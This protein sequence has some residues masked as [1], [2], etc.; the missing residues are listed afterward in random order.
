MEIRNGLS[1]ETAFIAEDSSGEMTSSMAKV[2]DHHFGGNDGDFFIMSETTMENK[3]DGNKYK[4]LFIE[5]KNK[6][7]FK[8][9]F[10]IG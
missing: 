1:L 5:D 10:K 8:V 3:E 7:K 4:V 2:I 9:Y 6:Q